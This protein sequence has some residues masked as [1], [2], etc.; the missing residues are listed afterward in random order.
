MEI[1]RLREMFGQVELCF[2]YCESNGVAD[3][4]AKYSS[5]ALPRDVNMQAYP[6][7]ANPLLRSLVVWFVKTYPL[8]LPDSYLWQ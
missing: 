4:L 8:A 7:V 5:G 6:Q 2:D 3:V 1:G